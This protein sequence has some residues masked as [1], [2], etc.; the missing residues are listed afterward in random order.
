[1][2]PMSYDY[3]EAQIERLAAAFAP[4]ARTTPVV[5][6]KLYV[7]AG[8][9]IFSGH[10][11]EAEAYLV[12]SGEVLISRN[13]HPIDLIEEGELLDLSLWPSATAVALSGCTLVTLSSLAQRKLS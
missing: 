6:P 9:P 5:V 11:V 8:H 2:H 7:A 4:F 10:E 12:T 1:M 13:G 3:H